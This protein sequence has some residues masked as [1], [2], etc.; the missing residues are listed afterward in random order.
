MIFVS[1]WQWWYVQGWQEAWRSFIRFI[2][3]LGGVFSIGL[4]LRTLF[5]P[6]KQTVNV[7]GPNTS[8]QLRVKWWVGNQVSRFIGFIIRS[9]TLLVATIGILLTF[10]SGASLL[11]LW[12]FIPLIMITLLVM[13]LVYIW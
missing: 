13:G 8:L 1:L 9:S 7:S 2:K 5:S 10:I 4:L 12:P 6:W 3:R 11:F